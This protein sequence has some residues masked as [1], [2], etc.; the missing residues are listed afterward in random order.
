MT[1]PTTRLIL[2]RHGQSV[3]HRENRYAGVSDIDLTEQGHRQAAAL[4]DWCAAH[5]PAA[6]YCSPVR[7]ARETAAPV[8]A[9]LGLPV[10][11]MDGLAEVDYGMAEGRTLAEV[12]ADAPDVAAGFRA[13]PVAHPFPGAEPPADA[14]ARGAAALREIAARGA[15]GPVLVVA[16][17]TLFRLALCALTGIPL[18]GYRAVLPRLDNGARTEISLGPTGPAAL[19]CLNVP[20]P[21]A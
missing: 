4:A 17:N 20:L 15:D 8:G 14:A 5:P 18:A 19:H 10:R 12:A 21:T 13:D 11:M 9:R 1:A 2:A 16:H 3:W 6:V 7:R